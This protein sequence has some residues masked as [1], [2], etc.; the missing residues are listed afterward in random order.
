M[1]AVSMILQRFDLSLGDPV[2]TLK[3]KQ[4][5]TMKPLNFTMKAKI[6]PEY[7][8]NRPSLSA[9]IPKEVTSDKSVI[10]TATT[11]GCRGRGVLVLYGSNSG[12]SEGLAQTIGEDAGKM[13]FWP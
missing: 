3:I 8:A 5:L 10:S 11:Q 7:V 4:T 2:Y 9:T 12:S 1:M 13:G 6:R